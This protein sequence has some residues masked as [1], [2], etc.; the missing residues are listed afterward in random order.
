MTLS[1]CRH[2]RDTEGV[3]RMSSKLKPCLA[4]VVA[5]H[6]HVYRHVRRAPLL[7][8]GGLRNGWHGPAL[9]P[10]GYARQHCAENPFSEP[11]G[12]PIKDARSSDREAA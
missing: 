9:R 12:E 5:A 1:G 7:A 2:Q 8:H 3:Q 11:S 10:V 6:Q 4:D